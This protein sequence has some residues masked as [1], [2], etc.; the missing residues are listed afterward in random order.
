MSLKVK[1]SKS[2]KAILLN[3]LISSSIKAGLFYYVSKVSI[4]L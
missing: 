1:R 2:Y 3:Y 4:D